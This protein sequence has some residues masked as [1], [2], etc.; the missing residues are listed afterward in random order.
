MTN[1]FDFE[2]PICGEAF[3]SEVIELAKHI[4]DEHDPSR[5]E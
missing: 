1:Q 5:S 3:G 4:G 2:C